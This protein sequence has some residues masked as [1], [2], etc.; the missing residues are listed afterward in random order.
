METPRLTGSMTIGILLIIVGSLFMLDNYNLINI[1]Y[2]YFSWQYWFIA[3]GLLFLLLSRNRT[4][5]IIFLAIGL[6][7]LM[8]ELWPLILVL[9]GLHILF[10]RRRAFFRHGNLAFK[11]AQTGTEPPKQGE[12]ND[13]VESFSIF[14]GGSKIIDSDNFRGGSILAIFGGSEIDLTNCKLADGENIIEVTAIFGGTTLM[15]PNDW[16]VNVDVLPVFGGFGDKRIKDPNKSFVEG[17]LLTI[18]GFVM[19]GGGEI[20]TN[21]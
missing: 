4:I 19:F 2:E 13:Y 15:V 16:K 1:P 18:K 21:F 11:I 14:S 10:G 17:K 7:N 20:K 12:I 8:P 6:F 3:I 9:I 5:G